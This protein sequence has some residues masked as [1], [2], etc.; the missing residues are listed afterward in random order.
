MAVETVVIGA[1]PAMFHHD[2]LA[3]I[4]KARDQVC[5]DDRA[6]G[7]G[8]H[9]IERFALLIA[10]ERADVDAF[11]KASVNNPSRRLDRIADESILTAL[12]RCRLNPF[13]VALDILIKLGT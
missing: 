3:V 5:V 12:P 13:E 10:L 4:G 6:R 7:N 2:I 11:M 1:V 8:A 9:R